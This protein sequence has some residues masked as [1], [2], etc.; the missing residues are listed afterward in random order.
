VGSVQNKTAVNQAADKLTKAIL[1]IPRR[2]RL[3]WLGILLGL[4]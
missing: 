4:P 1:V 3:V 2:D